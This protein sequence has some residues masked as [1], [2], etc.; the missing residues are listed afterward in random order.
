MG[1]TRPSG[2]LSQQAPDKW[3]VARKDLMRVRA[4]SRMQD[5][6]RQSFFRLTRFG[7]KEGA[8]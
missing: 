3:V 2:L 1:F 8:A 7:A 6:E 4:A 5:L